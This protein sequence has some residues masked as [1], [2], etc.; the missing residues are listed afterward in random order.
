MFLSWRSIR[1]LQNLSLCLLSHYSTELSIRT[2]FD[3]I[4]NSEYSV[5][6]CEFVELSIVVAKLMTCAVHLLSF[7]PCRF[8]HTHHKCNGK[9]VLTFL[10]LKVIFESR[11]TPLLVGLNSIDCHIVSDQSVSVSVFLPRSVKNIKIVLSHLLDPACD[12]FDRFFEYP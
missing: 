2:V 9:R 4:E 8:S 1:Q 6:N 11:I 3:R 12:L 7:G 5:F 10:F